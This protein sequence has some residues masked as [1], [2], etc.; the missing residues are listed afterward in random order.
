MS[1]L[2][3]W[4]QKVSNYCSP[5]VSGLR[6]NAFSRESRKIMRQSF[7]NSQRTCKSVRRVL[8]RSA[9]ANDARRCSS[10][11][12]HFSSGLPMSVYGICGR[13]PWRGTTQSPGR[14]GWSSDQF[15]MWHS[16][17]SSLGSKLTSGF[18]R[19]L[20]ARR[21]MQIWYSWK[22][23][24]EGFSDPLFTHFR[25]VTHSLRAEKTLKEVLKKQRNTVEEI[26]KKTNYYNT[27]N[28]IEKYD[29]PSPLNPGATPLRRRSVPPPSVPQTPIAPQPPQQQRLQ[30]PNGQ[31]RGPVFQLSRT[32]CH[33]SVTPYADPLAHL[34]TPQP[35]QAARKHWYDKLADAVLGDD[36]DQSATVAA[37][38]YALICQ[39]CFAHNGL[40]KE[41]VW[42]DTRE[43]PCMVG[44]VRRLL[45]I[46]P[47]EYVCPK[48]GFFNPSAR[49]RKRA[50]QRTPSPP[51]AQHPS[52]D[53]TPQQLSPTT[54]NVEGDD[55][56][57][58]DVE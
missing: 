8:P 4:F 54:P 48:C 53:Q 7:L 56:M 23:N 26:K 18:R 40:V 13:C 14:Q 49:S 16:G 3:R 6:I 24:R 9:C 15:C 12:G 27:R 34:A 17:H 31:V 29:E 5:Q 42:E 32:C 45:T 19:I 41:N 47:T 11:S 33:S 51:S 30:T 20:F 50:A 21:M 28:L 35:I 55:S 25:L 10:H 58:M 44:T 43:Y 46:I 52:P 22:G 39:K 37:S 57:H 2:T 38:R 36:D 1:F